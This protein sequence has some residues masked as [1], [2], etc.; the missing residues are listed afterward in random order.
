MV[1]REFGL[2]GWRWMGKYIRPVMIMGLGQ[3]SHDFWE[4]FVFVGVEMS[5]EGTD[6]LP[7]VWRCMFVGSTSDGNVEV[8]HVAMP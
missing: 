1:F 3:Y 5:D 7:G 8:R 4:S 2:E 6:V